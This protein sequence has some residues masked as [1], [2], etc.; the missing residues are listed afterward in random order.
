MEKNLYKSNNMIDHLNELN[1]LN[2]E[3]KIMLNI[4][5]NELEKVI[6]KFYFMIL[7]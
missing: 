5:I 2:Y 7:T 1:S 4:T 3:N 6:L